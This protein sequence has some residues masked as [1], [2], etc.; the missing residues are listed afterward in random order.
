MNIKIIAFLCIYWL[1]RVS[2]LVTNTQLCILSPSFPARPPAMCSLLVCLCLPACLRPATKNQNT[3]TATHTCMSIGQV[4]HTTNN[5]ITTIDGRTCWLRQTETKND[6]VALRHTQAV[7]I[8]R[9]VEHGAK[10]KKSGRTAFDATAP[11]PHDYQ[12]AR[13]PFFHD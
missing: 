13:L 1:Y 9:S 7:L 11:E 10:A 8:K 5:S 12:V 4:P 6:R 2:H 3:T